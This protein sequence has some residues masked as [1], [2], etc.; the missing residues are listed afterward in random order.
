METPRADA[1]IFE[2]GDKT[3]LRLAHDS[4]SASFLATTTAILL[5]HGG[6]VFI[7]LVP[8]VVVFTK[9]DWL[10]RIKEADLRAENSSLSDHVRREQGKEEAQKAFEER[11]RS[12]E[13]TLRET[14]TPR[15]PHVKV[16]CI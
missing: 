15:P 8:V 9:Y 4:G 11:I 12:L 1:C 3:L 13:R 7:K 2:T 14:N 16:S 10:V 5:T 6:F